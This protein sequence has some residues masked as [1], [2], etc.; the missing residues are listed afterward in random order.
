MVNI[1][2]SLAVLLLIMLI[3]TGAGCGQTNNGNTT[4]QESG[5]TAEPVQAGAAK[6][7]VDANGRAVTVPEK[8][9]RIAITCQG[10][11]AQEVTILGSGD[12]IV[13]QAPMN[14]FPQLLKMFPKYKDIV[15]PGTFDNVNIEE[16]IKADPD[17]VLVGITSKKGNQLIEEAGFPTF[18][19][20][21]GWAGI[22]T[23]KNEFLQMGTL[24]GNEAKAEQLVKYWDEKLAYINELVS[25]VP[26]NEKKSVLYGYANKG[27][28]TVHGTGVW[29]DSLITASGGL[30]A[31]AEISESKE[32]SVE[33]IMTWNPDIIILQKSENALM[34]IRNDPRISDLDALKNDR[35][36]QVPIGAFWWD[37][38]SPESPLGFMWLATKLYP[39]Y[40]KD[41]DLKKETK[42]FFKTFYSYDLSDEEYN[43]FF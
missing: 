39:E 11:T 28:A 2:K 19:M 21:I 34:E 8:I 42:E 4:V 1:R 31:A 16:I 33:Q 40:T 35:V 43:S 10:G 9:N 18:T 25:K 29:G 27:L 22:D 38:P 6:Q 14:A 12:K 17:I 20:L 23:L 41:I 7:V 15:N 3:L 32:V 30:N 5:S 26:E 24:L 37:R 36:Y 13:A